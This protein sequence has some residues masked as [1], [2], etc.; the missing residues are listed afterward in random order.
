MTPPMLLIGFLA[1]WTDA[2]S[3]TRVRLA[4][5]QIFALALAM[6]RILSVYECTYPVAV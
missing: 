3:F 2:I 5:R 6:W 1:C 4:W